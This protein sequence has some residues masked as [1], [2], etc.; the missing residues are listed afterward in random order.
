MS[1]AHPKCTKRRAALEEIAAQRIP[2]TKPLLSLRGRDEG[3]VM[4]DVGVTSDST[5]IQGVPRCHCVCPGSSPDRCLAR[6]LPGWRVPVIIGGC[7]HATWLAD[8]GCAAMGEACKWLCPDITRF[9]SLG[10]G[11]GPLKVLCK[12]RYVLRSTYLGNPNS[13]AY[14]VARC[15]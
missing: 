10:C 6:A 14:K 3:G 5:R 12:R 9:G 2:R 1:R 4:D 15:R 11:E 8:H 13:R 7:G